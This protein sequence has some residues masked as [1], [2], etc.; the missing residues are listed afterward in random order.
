MRTLLNIIYVTVV[1]FILYNTHIATKKVSALE[2][3]VAKQ[4]LQIDQLRTMNTNYF[5]RQAVI[6]MIIDK[7]V[8]AL[9]KSK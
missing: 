6:D 9:E 5:Y 2:S 1:A 3:Q 4:N 8:E 7:R